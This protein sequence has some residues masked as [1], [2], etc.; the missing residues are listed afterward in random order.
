M[1]GQAAVGLT[2]LLSHSAAGVRCGACNALGQL[3]CSALL[4]TAELV[5]CSCV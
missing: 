2:P 5:T 4:L 1:E 3:S